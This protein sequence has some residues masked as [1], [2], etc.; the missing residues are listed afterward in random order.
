MVGALNPMKAFLFLPV[1]GLPQPTFAAV[2]L[3][4]NRFSKNTNQ[5]F[6]HSRK[7]GECAEPKY[8]VL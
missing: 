4:L 7:Q 6:A 8:F 3:D 2:Q 1:S 5:Y